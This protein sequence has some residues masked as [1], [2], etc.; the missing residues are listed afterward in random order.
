MADRLWFTDSGLTLYSLT[1]VFLNF[2][3]SDVFSWSPSEKNSCFWSMVLTSATVYCNKMVTLL[4][5]WQIPRWWGQISLIFISPVFNIDW[6]KI[7]TMMCS[8]SL[9]FLDFDMYGNFQLVDR[10]YWE[11]KWKPVQR[12]PSSYYIYAI[13]SLFQLWKS[14]RKIETIQILSFIESVSSKKI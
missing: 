1:F 8:L 11:K 14:V 10:V 6:M 5:K 13:L 12:R 4:R 2:L 9:K 7:W 3:L